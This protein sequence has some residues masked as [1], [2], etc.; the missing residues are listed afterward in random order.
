MSP[1]ISKKKSEPAPPAASKNPAEILQRYG[2]DLDRFAGPD[3][4][5]ERHLAFDNIK[6]PAAIGPRERFEA[7]ARSIR[8]VLSARWVATE[9]TYD[10]KDPKRVYYLSMEFLIGRSLGNNIINLLLG[11]LAEEIEAGE[12]IDWLELLEQE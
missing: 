9:A 11:P 4:L 7:A 12:R 8:D 1:T 5:Y 2:C 10:R 3:G 6:A